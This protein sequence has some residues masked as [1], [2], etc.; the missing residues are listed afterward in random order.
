M[1]QHEQDKID[2]LASGKF[3]EEMRIEFRKRVAEAVEKTRQHDSKFEKKPY[4]QY[5]VE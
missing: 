4:Y 2:N 5:F 1:K 3:T